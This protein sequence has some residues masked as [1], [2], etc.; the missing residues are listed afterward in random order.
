MRARTALIKLMLLGLLVLVLAGGALFW[1]VGLPGSSGA[2]RWIGRQLQAVVS[3]HL[4]AEL[5]FDDLDYQYPRAVDVTN[6]R[7]TADDPDRPGERVDVIRAEAVHLE[8]AEIPRE[9]QPVRISQLIL[10]R[11]LLRVITRSDQEPRFVGLSNL[12]KQPAERRPEAIERTVRLSEVFHIRL[13]QLI[14]GEVHYEPRQEGKLPAMRL[15]G[16][17]L[18][19]DIAADEG[20]WYKLGGTLLREPVLSLTAD[21]RLNLDEMVLDVERMIL[22]ARLARDHDRF[23][24]PQIQK[25]L[26]E[27]EV[28]GD[29]KVDARGTI[30]LS[31]ATAARLTATLGLTDANFAAGEYRGLI[32]TA[33]AELGMADR[34]LTLANLLVRTLGGEVKGR[35]EVGLGEGGRVDAQLT[36]SGL[37]V[38]ETLRSAAGGTGEPKY[39]GVLYATAAFNAPRDQLTT[40]AGG[41]GNVQLYGGRMSAMPGFAALNRALLTALTLDGQSSGGAGDRA[42]VHFAFA[43]DKVVLSS[44]EAYTPA[45]SLRGD[46]EIGFDG[47]LDLHLAASPLGHVRRRLGPLGDVLGSVTEQAVTYHVTGRAGGEVNVKPE[48][49]GGLRRLLEG[50]GR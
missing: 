44:L 42:E 38:E 36:A 4:N 24:P 35:A 14:D 22:S 47:G 12:V 43:G 48:P 11:P 49:L 30:P 23:L 26:I 34:K 2:E 16:I 28:T 8:L 37:R 20:G 7:L 31:D 5:T 9:G 19:L 13:L 41:Q 17:N 3:T 40:R 15:D 25:L 6:F 39:G 18:R 45:Y 10:R 32:K 46:G 21:G 1:W 27:H 33:G 50:E 29:L